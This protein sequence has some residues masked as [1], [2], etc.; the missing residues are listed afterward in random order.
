MTS[1]VQDVLIF[2]RPEDDLDHLLNTEVPDKATLLHSEDEEEVH[3]TYQK[4]GAVIYD[5]RWHFAGDLAMFGFTAE[6][7][8]ESG[9]VWLGLVNR[10]LEALS[11]DTVVIRRHFVIE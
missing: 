7:A 4:V 11:E 9:V 1:G 6:A 10:M 8:E 3:Q 2:L 5:G